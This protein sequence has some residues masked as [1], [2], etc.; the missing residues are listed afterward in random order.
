MALSTGSR[1]RS[2][3]PQVESLEC[4]VLLSADLPTAA[5]PITMANGMQIPVS[6]PRL[7]FT[8]ES[9]DH[10]RE[11]VLSHPFTP[12]RGGPF[13]NALRYV[14]GGGE[15]YGRVAVDALMAF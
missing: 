6:H 10:A 8:P 4:R 9:L 2:S 1:L 7:W 12:H 15:S 3:A 14:L 11:W 5:A 13:D